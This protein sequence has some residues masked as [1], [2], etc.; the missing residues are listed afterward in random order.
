[1]ARSQ[2]HAE[3]VDT[4]AAGQLA[5]ALVNYCKKTCTLC[6]LAGR[7]IILAI[8]QGRHMHRTFCLTALLGLAFGFIASPQGGESTQILGIVEDTSGSVV[9]GVIITVTQVGTGQQRQVTSG[10]SGNYVITNIIPGEYTIRAEKQGFKS[11]VR[12]GLVLQLNQKARVDM[13]LSVGTVT[14]TVEVSARG[15]ILNTDDATIGNVVEQKRIVDST[16][17]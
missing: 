6:A 16:L 11:E 12:T 17:R 3:S 7:G 5:C 1:M 15:V 8:T 13:R 10:D 2:D 14:E 9:P 4:D